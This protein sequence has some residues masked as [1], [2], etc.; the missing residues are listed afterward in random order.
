MIVVAIAV[1]I[2]VT[3]AIAITIVIVIA[4][5]HADTA[6]TNTVALLTHLFKS[7]LFWVKVL[8]GHTGEPETINVGEKVAGAMFSLALHKWMCKEILHTASW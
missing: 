3:I 8:F 1:T 7:E 4:I 6:L 2:A 5:K